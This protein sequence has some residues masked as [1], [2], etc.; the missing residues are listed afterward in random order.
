LRAYAFGNDRDLAEIAQA[1]VDRQLR[2]DPVA[3]T[4]EE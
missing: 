1:V 4:H 3:D 2:F